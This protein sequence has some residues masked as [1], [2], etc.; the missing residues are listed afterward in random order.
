MF[1]FQLLLCRQDGRLFVHDINKREQLC[2]LILPDA[3]DG[4]NHRPLKPA[5]FSTLDCGRNVFVIGK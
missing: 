1:L 2:E 3:G 5:A 4:D